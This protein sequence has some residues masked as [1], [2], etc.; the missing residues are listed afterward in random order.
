MYTCNILIQYNQS[1]D[2]QRDKKNVKI[3]YRVVDTYTL[4]IHR[5]YKYFLYRFF[6]K[7]KNTYYI[8]KKKL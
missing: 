1:L 8:L 4:Y 6:D 7:V 5:I 3:V 2:I